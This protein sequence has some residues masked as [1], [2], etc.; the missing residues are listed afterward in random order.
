LLGLSQGQIPS[1]ALFFKDLILCTPINSWRQVS[2]LLQVILGSRLDHSYAR[3]FDTDITFSWINCK[4]IRI[5]KKYT[6][7]H[8]MEVKV[9]H[10]GV[11]T[12]RT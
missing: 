5:R 8:G 4:V 10:C 6:P 2:H 7:A 12:S 3:R 11:R 9:S 1:P